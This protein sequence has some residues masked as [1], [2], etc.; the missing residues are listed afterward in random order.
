MR[1]TSTCRARCSSGS[2]SRRAS[3]Q[4]L[5]DLLAQASD[6]YDAAD[7][8]E[9]AARAATAGAAASATR[10]ASGPLLEIPVNCE[11]YNL[12]YVP[13]VLERAGVEV[14]RDMGA[15]TSPPRATIVERTD[16]AVRGFAQRG[17]DAW[18]TMYT[19]FA[20]QLWSCGGQRLR[21]RPLR[22]RLARVDPG[23]GGLRRRAP[24]RRPDRLAGPALVRARARLRAGPL[25]AHRR[26]RSL[27]RVLRGS[28]D[29]AARRAR[30]PTR[31]RR[32][33]RPA[34]GGRTSGRGRS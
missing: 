20:T 22:D 7:F 19:G 15:S 34:S 5:D 8:F 16:G 4:P 17:T 2:T 18:H 24:R 33:A 28:G 27:R 1:P 11:S 14:P 3:S 10:S 29:L 6:G 32:S 21:G 23:D 12:A 30:S 9:P 26:L 13:A 31:R 25:R